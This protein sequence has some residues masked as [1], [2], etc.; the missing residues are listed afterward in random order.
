[1]RCRTNHDRRT[2]IRYV[3]IKG[4]YTH[5]IIYNVLK[6]NIYTE[7]YIRV[8]ALILEQSLSLYLFCKYLNRK[9]RVYVNRL[10]TI[11]KLN[12]EIQGVIGEIQ[13]RPEIVIENFMKRICHQS[14]VGYWRIFISYL[15]RTC[16][17]YNTIKNHNSL[18]K[19][20]F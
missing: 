12:S 9:S 3:I 6:L 8:L 16:L 1:M 5:K 4:Y 13:P 15:I 14:W 11:P 20:M 10:E 18:K 7:P 2:E 19:Y 17:L